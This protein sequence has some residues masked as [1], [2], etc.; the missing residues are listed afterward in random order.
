MELTTLVKE[1]RDPDGSVKIAIGH[2]K[3]YAYASCLVLFLVDLSNTFNIRFTGT[4]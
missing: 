3:K 4:G 1:K 2:P